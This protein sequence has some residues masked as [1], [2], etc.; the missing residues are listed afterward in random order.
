MYS[1]PGMEVVFLLYFYKFTC[2]GQ[3]SGVEKLDGRKETPLHE[4]TSHCDDVTEIKFNLLVVGRSQ[5]YKSSM[6]KN[7]T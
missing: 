4:G 5:R 1:K 6:Q 2:P 7:E 3:R